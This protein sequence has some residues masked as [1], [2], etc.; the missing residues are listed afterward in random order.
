MERLWQRDYANHVEAMTDI[1]DVIGFYNSVSMLQ[2]G[3]PASTNY[4]CK[5]SIDSV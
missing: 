5:P 1:A 3:L 4:E 2:P